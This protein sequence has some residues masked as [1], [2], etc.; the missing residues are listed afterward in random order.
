MTAVCMIRFVGKA[1]DLSRFLAEL[2]AEL[3]G[4]TGM[5]QKEEKRND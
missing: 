5:L 4:K 2:S 3:S 1:K